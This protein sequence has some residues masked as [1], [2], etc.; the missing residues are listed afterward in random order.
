MAIV[1][2]PAFLDRFPEKFG[3]RTTECIDVVESPIRRSAF[4]FAGMQFEIYYGDRRG[5]PFVVV[6]GNQGNDRI[7]YYAYSVPL[8]LVTRPDRE[9]LD[10]LFELFVERF[11]HV[12][13][14][15]GYRSRCIRGV[16][17]RVT[18]E[19]L[20]A[21]ELY[22]QFRVENSGQ[23]FALSVTAQVDK[24]VSG[25]RVR[26]ALVYSLDD[27]AYRTWLKSVNLLEWA[28]SDPQPS[29]QRV[30]VDDRGEDAGLSDA[31]AYT[32]GSD[33]RVMADRFRELATNMLRKE[34]LQKLRPTHP[35]SRLLSALNATYDEV[36]ASDGAFRR[37]LYSLAELSINAGTWERTVDPA[38]LW[39]IIVDPLLKN[40]IEGRL[41]DESQYHDTLA[42][43]YI[44]GS[45]R[46]K[47]IT[48][49][50]TDDPGMPDLRLYVSAS[51]VVPAEVKVV[52]EGTLPAA[53]RRHIEKANRQI[54]RFAPDRGGIVYMFFERSEPARVQIDA[55]EPAG[56]LIPYREAAIKV[57][58][59]TMYRSVASVVLIWDEYLAVGENADGPT[60]YAFRRQFEVLHHKSGRPTG[61]LD[62]RIYE[63]GFSMRL[64]DIRQHNI[65]RN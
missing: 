14:V 51:D 26:C 34:S 12:I 46:Q 29:G 44:W 49:E 31:I 36:T 15:N 39:S 9:D 62:E 16:Y 42:E 4:I 33:M 52:H 50:L 25:L 41:I 10:H 30:R 3:I 28:A 27:E 11:G 7:I 56:F 57:L 8:D 64:W 18:A 23:N 59:S 55:S 40:R 21:I 65:A 24:Q 32:R 35:L 20:P 60:L 5:Y 53:V 17:F 54:K 19:S 37:W 47:G 13:E 43:L 38:D 22:H 6:C 2:A 58:A 1:I 45:M 48:T 63:V 61:P